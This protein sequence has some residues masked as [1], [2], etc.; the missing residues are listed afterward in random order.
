MSRTSASEVTHKHPASERGVALITTLLVLS[1]MTALSF[2]MYLSV[3]SDMLINTYYRNFRGSFYAADSGLNI[4]RAMLVNQVQLQVPTSF[5][6]PPL[7][8]PSLVAATAT[9]NMLNTYGSMTSLTSG[10]TASS[11]PESFKITNATLGLAPSSPT[12]TSRDSSGNPTGYSYIYNYAITSQGT[13]RGS[14]QA[15]V[16]EKGSFTFNITGAASTTNVSFAAF[17]GFVDQYPQCLGPLVPGTMTGPM[18]TNGAWEFMTGGDYIFTDP[19]GQADANADYWIDWN[20]FQSPSK[21]Y[22]YDNQ[23]IKPTFQGGFNLNQPKV[24]LPSN[25]FSQK[26][27]VLDGKGL[28]TAS[29]TNSDLNA[30]LKDVSGTAY[31]SGGASS[32]VFFPYSSSGGAN[33]MSGG[34]IY[35][36]GDASIV[37]APSGTSAQVYTITQGSTTTVVTTDPLAA[38]PAGWNCPAGTVGTTTIVSGSTTTNVCSVPMN[39]INNTPATMLYVN[40]AIPSLSGPGPGQGAIQ[41]GTQLTITAKNDITAT[42]DV[43]Y[44]T[45]PVTTTQNQIVPGTNPPCCDGT[46]VDTLIPGNDRNQVLGIFTLT[47]NFN[48]HVATDW[49]NIQVD[50]SIAT[51]SNGGTGGFLNTGAC[52]NTFNNVGGQIQNSIYGACMAVQNIYFDRRFTN[53]PGFA[54]P[55]FPSTT[56]TQGGAQA[57]NVITTVQRVQWMNQTTLQ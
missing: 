52:V 34:G 38:P 12:V 25:D 43:L 10:S 29:P 47:G 37:L 2:V 27:A 17:G 11:W 14:Q 31:P 30:T 6:T 26:R 23:L 56:V 44:K 16:S 24:P 50:G 20:C 49:S 1:I 21:T 15:T 13:S 19:V 42:G 22:S 28:N 9:T 55:W 41:D 7:A 4:A 51:I 46:P 32:G 57:T 33:V 18:F 53:K 35:V 39:L 36:E 45:E 48:T 40:G 54:P 5:T 8:N 3:N